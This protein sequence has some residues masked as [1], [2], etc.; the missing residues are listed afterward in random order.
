MGCKVGDFSMPFSTVFG[1]VLTFLQVCFA[2]VQILVYEYMKNGNLG[3]H[4]SS[5]D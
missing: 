1:G 4:I 2:T 5:K 3:E